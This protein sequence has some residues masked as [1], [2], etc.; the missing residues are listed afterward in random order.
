MIEFDY[1]SRQNCSLGGIANTVI[2]HFGTGDSRELLTPFALRSKNFRQSF[3]S[4]SFLKSTVK[5][6]ASGEIRRLYERSDYPLR[7]RAA[8]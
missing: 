4:A 5:D 8:I 6:N 1:A 2:N 3:L 7:R